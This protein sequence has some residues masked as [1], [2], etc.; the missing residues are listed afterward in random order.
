MKH[1]IVLVF[2]CIWV[3]VF[4]SCNKTVVQQPVLLIEQRTN[5]PESLRTIYSVYPDGTHLHQLF[6]FP[7]GSGEYWLSPNKKQLALLTF[8]GTS[9][10][11][12]QTLTIIDLLSGD[13]LAQVEDVGYVYSNL[14]SYRVFEDSVVWS[15]QGDKLIFERNAFNSEN[16]D[17]W[18]F[19]LATET[20]TPLT[21]SISDNIHPSWSPDGTKI[22]FTS[23]ES[24]GQRL[25]E[26]A[27]DE[28]YWNIIIADA[29]G[30][31]IRS[32]T[33]FRNTDFFIK[34][35]HF[36]AKML[37][38]LTWSPDSEYIAFENSCFS[39][40]LVNPHDIF[41]VDIAGEKL[42]RVTDF[43]LKQRLEDMTTTPKSIFTV[44]FSIQW[45]ESGDM[46]YIGYSQSDYLDRSWSLFG[47]FVIANI[48]TGS[49]FHSTEIFGL[50]GQRSWSPDTTQFVAFTSRLSNGT[51][52][53]G[54]TFLGKL[55]PQNGTISLLGL[56]ND[57]PY[58]S[59]DEPKTY[60]SPEGQYVAYAMAQE[61][62][63]CVDEKL[64]RG[65]AVISLPD[66]QV[67]NVV[68]S[69]AG[70]NLPIGWMMIDDM[71]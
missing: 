35:D 55:E 15:P 61:G 48:E 6:Q 13:S 7:R 40:S 39:D 43:A 11:P 29:D 62:E 70:D 27:P 20:I 17:L 25:E 30:S 23:W 12:A 1:K 63:T 60:W 31:N 44:G 58:G 32:I 36:S 42:E 28:Q 38:N 50:R 45:A 46:L 66:G 53:S 57:L 24:C 16:T 52:T 19:D 2:F 64:N 49:I 47:G 21:K 68:E 37:C 26:C 8:W 65:I 41:V 4:S 22:A 69:L 34:S 51:I 59:C 18:L 71:G 9:E 14:R 54:P 33:D 67:T 5:A 10:F 56:P 3:V